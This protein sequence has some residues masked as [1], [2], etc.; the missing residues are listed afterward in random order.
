[1]CTVFKYENKLGTF[2]LVAP[3]EAVATD[4]KSF[5]TARNN[6]I[7]IPK[8]PFQS[9]LTLPIIKHCWIKPGFFHHLN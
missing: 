8:Y 7:P 4:I 6:D 9:D 5:N 3:G 2:N 1:M